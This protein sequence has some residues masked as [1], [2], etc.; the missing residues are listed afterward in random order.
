ML[1]SP[2]SSAG[3]PLVVANQTR[4][5]VRLAVAQTNHGDDGAAAELWQVSETVPEM[6]LISTSSASETSSLWWM[7]LMSMLSQSPRS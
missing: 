2:G 4:E 3:L 1:L 7:R 5:N 6:L